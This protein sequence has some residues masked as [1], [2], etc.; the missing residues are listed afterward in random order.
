M[1]STFV[2]FHRGGSG[3]PLVCLHGFTDTWRTWELVLPALERRH[4][5]LA[6]TLA[7]HAGGP[8]IDG[9]IGEAAIADA[10]E[11]AMDEAGFATAHVVGNSLGGYIALQLAARGRAQTVVALAPA[12]GWAVGDES[13]R[14][15]LAYF[16]TMQALLRTAAPH[17]DAIVSTPEG[18]RRAT[19]YT[20]ERF[21]HIPSELLAHQM[22]GAASCAAA[23]PLVEHALREGWSLDAERIDC[24][25]RVVWGTEDRLLLW[26]SAAARFRTDWL[27]QADW[28][29]LEGVG[30]CPQLDVPLETAEL[31]LGFTAR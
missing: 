23:A 31:I 9:E 6:L 25:V 17:A 26:P 10:V 20:A 28:V 5:V 18:R 7:G 11:R 29:E 22:R 24:P 12:G 14:D 30:H 19:Q 27:P 4:D 21:E 13:F 1:D 2:P 3:P 15:V 8:G 16:T